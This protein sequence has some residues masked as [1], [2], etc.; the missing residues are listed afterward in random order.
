MSIMT[1]NLRLRTAV[2]NAEKF[3]ELF[4]TL[5]DREGSGRVP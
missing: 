3:I 4:F 1:I 5:D 2:P